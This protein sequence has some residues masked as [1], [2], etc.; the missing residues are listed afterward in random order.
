MEIGYYAAVPPYLAAVRFKNG[1]HSAVVVCVE[2]LKAGV[3]QDVGCGYRERRAWASRA[4]SSWGSPLAG[5]SGLEASR[6]G[7][8]EAAGRAMGTP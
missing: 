6:D 3:G 2:K 4:A 5:C 1:V 8:R 7:G